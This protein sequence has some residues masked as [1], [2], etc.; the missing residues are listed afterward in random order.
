MDIETRAHAEFFDLEKFLASGDNFA[1]M[2]G[3]FGV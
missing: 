1:V 2:E 3:L